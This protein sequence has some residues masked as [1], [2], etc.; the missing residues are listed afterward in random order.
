[1][2]TGQ[3]VGKVAALIDLAWSSAE[4]TI[5]R[6]SER[7]IYTRYLEIPASSREQEF[8]TSLPPDP[9]CPLSISL[10]PIPLPAILYDG[11]SVFEPSLWTTTVCYPGTSRIRARNATARILSAIATTISTKSAV[12]A[13]ACHAILAAI[14]A[15]KHAVPSTTTVLAATTATQCPI[16]AT[17]YHAILASTTATRHEHKCTGHCDGEKEEGERT[18]RLLFLVRLVHQKRSYALLLHLL[19]LMWI[20]GGSLEGVRHWKI[21]V[22][23]WERGPLT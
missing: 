22:T 15:S 12:H 9:H 17:A 8:C 1:L 14:T 20:S 10:Q 11:F 4:A 21:G 19:P 18:A 13:T 3:A 6:C 23:K 2:E 7:Y 16:P 5:A